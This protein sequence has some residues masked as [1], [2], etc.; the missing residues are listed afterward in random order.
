M[1]TALVARAPQCTAR[2]EDR[3]ARSSRQAVV[4]ARAGTLE[5]LS[6]HLGRDARF[7]TAMPTSR[8]N[9]ATRAIFSN[10]IFDTSS[11]GL[12]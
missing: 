9:R 4:S 6:S 10:S 7:A 12:W 8:I 3:L 2:Y 1:R 5:A 11:L